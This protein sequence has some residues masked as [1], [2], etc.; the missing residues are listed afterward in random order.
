MP[1]K[2]QWHW[3]GKRQGQGERA[4]QAIQSQEERK[5]TMAKRSSGAKTTRQLVDNENNAAEGD[6]RWQAMVG[7]VWWLVEVGG[8]WP[9]WAWLS[10]ST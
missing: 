4:V 2:G 5:K 3:Q 1:W 8:C 9:K 7:T 6:G 10:A